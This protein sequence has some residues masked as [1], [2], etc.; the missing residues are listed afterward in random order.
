MISMRKA[1][2]Y[3][4]N[5][6]YRRSVRLQGYDYSRGGAYFVT[7]CTQDRARLLGEVIGSHIHV[8]AAGQMIAE[9]WAGLPVR[10]PMFVGDAFIVMPDHLHGVLILLDK[11]GEGV[12]PA[13][14]GDM[15]DHPRGTLPGTIG[16][17]LQ[18][19]KS[20]ST[21]SYIQGVEQQGW[22]PFAGRLW[23]RDYYEH[24]I[25]SE[26]ALERFRVYIDANPARWAQ[27]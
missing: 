27:T 16:R 24:I 18:A 4:P 6:H 26:Q 20:I 21:H 2:P 15:N 22:P 1:M 17:I 9:M 8:S 13:E 12:K 5:I 10:F 23:Q 3:D 7:I 25:R 19:F 14:V 11:V